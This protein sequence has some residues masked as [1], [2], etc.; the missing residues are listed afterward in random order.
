GELL[1]A[2]GDPAAVDAYREAVRLTTGEMRRKARIALSRTAT[3]SG[4]LESGADALAGL[5]SNGGPS[6]VALLLARGHLAYFEGD[7]DAAAAIAQ[8]ARS[9]IVTGDEQRQLLELIALQG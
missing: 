7:L 4:D 5:E 9:L 8:E 2:V 6:D 1:A 3:M